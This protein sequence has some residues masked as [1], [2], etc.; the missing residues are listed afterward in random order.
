MAFV[1]VAEGPTKGLTGPAFSKHGGCELIVQKR[2]SL[3]HT[4]TAIGLASI[5][6]KH[7]SN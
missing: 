5:D 2:L 1:P 6:P 4:H 7:G 3:S